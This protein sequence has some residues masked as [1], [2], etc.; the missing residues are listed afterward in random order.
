MLFE[1]LVPTSAALRA[2][3]ARGIVSSLLSPKL[4]TE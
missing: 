2:R 4:A 1:I 3:F